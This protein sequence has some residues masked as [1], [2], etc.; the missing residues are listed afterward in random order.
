MTTGLLGVNRHFQ[1]YSTR[2]LFSALA[3]LL[4]P[5]RTTMLC[6][7]MLL[8]TSRGVFHKSIN[9]SAST[10]GRKWQMKQDGRRLRPLWSSARTH[11]R[12]R[13]QSWRDQEMRP[14]LA[15]KP[16]LEVATTTLSTF[17]A[18][19]DNGSVYAIRCVSVCLNYRLSVTY[20]RYL[21]FSHTSS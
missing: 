13:L 16:S 5:W 15:R 6:V 11:N 12:L 7:A 14:C 21:L 2:S 18:D 3:E 20:L 9:D 19:C 8:T 1:Y 4:R 10:V 17:L